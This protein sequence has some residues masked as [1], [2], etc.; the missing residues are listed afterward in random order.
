MD[1]QTPSSSQKVRYAVRFLR[2]DLNTAAARELVSCRWRFED[3]KA[4]RW[5][6]KASKSEERANA[7]QTLHFDEDGWS[8]YHYFESNVES[9]ISVS[10]HDSH[11][12]P[13]V[14]GEAAGWAQRHVDL[15]P[16]KRTGQWAPFGLELVQLAATLLVPVATLASTTSNGATVGHWWQLIG[17]GFGADTI[18]N[19]IAG[20]AN[21]PPPAAGN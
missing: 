5:V 2:E 9:T 13:I 3:A 17:I 14:L 18:K 8:V 4:L 6:S 11:G 10:F 7:S 19:L 16:V 12:S 21:A 15:P 20:P 1:P